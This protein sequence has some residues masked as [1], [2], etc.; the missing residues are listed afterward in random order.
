MSALLQFPSLVKAY[1]IKQWWNIFPWWKI[2]PIA[3]FMPVVVVYMPNIV[4]ITYLLT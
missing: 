4:V 3:G 2:L 1:I